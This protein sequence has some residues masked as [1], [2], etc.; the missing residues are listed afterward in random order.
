MSL[1]WP[2]RADRSCALICA[3]DAVRQAGTGDRGRCLVTWQS[4]C[5]ARIVLRSRSA[6]VETPVVVLITQRRQGG[7]S[8]MTVPV[9]CP[10]GQPRYPFRTSCSWEAPGMAEPGDEIAESAGG[11]SHLR[12]SHADREQVIGVLK[13]AFV[14]GRLARDEFDL[15]VG[16]T[17]ASQA[18]ADLAALTAD[19]PAGLTGAELPDPARKSANKTAVTA[20]ACVSAA[21]TSIWLPVVIVDGI[22]SLA[23]LVLLVVLISVVPV[24]LAGL[25]LYH[26]WLDKRAGRQSSPGLPPGAGAGGEASQRL[27]PADL[28][29]QLPQINRDSW[30]AAE[31]A[32]IR[33]P[34]PALPSWAPLD[35]WHPLGAPVRDRL[36]RPLTRRPRRGTGRLRGTR[37]RMRVPAADLHVCA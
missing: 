27:A 4:V 25:L 22:N 29:G 8:A 34:R 21:W 5:P 31:A 17:L 19:I 30:D 11:H 18:Y 26:A 2:G 1:D 23:N 3:R 35:Q 14:Q 6:T 15:R 20:V 28:A 24:S 16:Q 9:A 7:Q 10:R 33:R 37:H 13:A 12:A 32:P 36:P